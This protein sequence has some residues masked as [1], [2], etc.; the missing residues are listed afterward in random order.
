MQESNNFNHKVLNYNVIVKELPTENVTDGGLD[1]S[2]TTDK[3]EKYRKGLVLAVGS[4]C[5]DECVSFFGIK[6]SFLKRPKLKSGKEVLFDNYKSSEITIDG[7]TYKN[8][9]YADLLLI[10]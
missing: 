7:V 1:I 4:L 2:S 5:P 9:L 6:I 3:S 10:L 8:I